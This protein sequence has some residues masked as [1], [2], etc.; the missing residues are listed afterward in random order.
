[1]SPK[2]YPI[3]NPSVESVFGGAE[4]DLYLL[5]TELAKDD[6]FEVR[7]VVAD[8]GQPDEEQRE[9]VRILK[10][11]NFKQNSLTGAVKIWRALKRAGADWIMLETASPGVPL[12]RVFCRQYGC[13]ML[14]R[15]AS[16]REC[17]GTYIREK[18]L[19]GRL[20]TRSLKKC[21]C[22]VTQN[23]RDQD[24]MHNHFGVEST[25]IP[26]GHRIPNLAGVDKDSILWVGRSAA[27]KGPGRFIEL[28]AALPEESFV[29]V[30]QKAT[31]DT[32]YDAL[33]TAAAKLANL[34]FIERVPFHDI[35]SCFQS[36]KVFVNTSDSEGFPN[37]FIQACKAGTAI[38]SFGVNPDYFLDT[39]RCGVAC[40]FSQER[41]T[42]QLKKML[43]EQR[44]N[45][46]GQHGQEY[47]AANHDIVRIAER[48][49]DIFKG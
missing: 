1:M 12:G 16:Q 3:F 23:Q 47:A 9:N 10:S 8:Y 5:A 24:L 38:L 30:C 15:T 22:V 4:V 45:E 13:R 26:N 35:D 31:G 29:M 44:Y 27:I 14:Y 18:P 46:L 20:F 32:R 36:A 2:A 39:H 17:D 41:M 6:A 34:R 25:V 40:D 37:T 43:N 11:V 49:K 28:A 42:E 48:Y 7:F 21:D 19:L 33:R